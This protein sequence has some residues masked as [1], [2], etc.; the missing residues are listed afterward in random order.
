[1]LRHPKEINGGLPVHLGGYDSRRRVLKS[2]ALGQ[3]LAGV[4]AEVSDDEAV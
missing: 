4:E 2:H 1:M 3:R